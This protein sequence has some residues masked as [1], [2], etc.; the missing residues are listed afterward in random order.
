M[1]QLVKSV[2]AK[3]NDLSLIPGPHTVRE[4]DLWGTRVPQRSSSDAPTCTVACKCPHTYALKINESK[5]KL[6]IT[7]LWNFGEIL[8]PKRF[9]MT[10]SVTEIEVFLLYLSTCN[11]FSLNKNWIENT[12]DHHEIIW[13][14]N[15]IFLYLKSWGWKKDSVKQTSL[16][17][18]LRVPRS[19]IDSG[20]AECL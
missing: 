17:T 1:A 7:K 2:A 5:K 3:P 12:H 10:I 20:R 18:E 13:I 4:T 16:S 8:S 19:H 6:H 9:I 14:S 11:I 15:S